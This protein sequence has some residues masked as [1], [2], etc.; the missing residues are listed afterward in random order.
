MHAYRGEFPI[1]F[2][3]IGF[4]TVVEGQRFLELFDLGDAD[5]VVDVACGT[6]GP[7]LWVAQQTGAFVVGI[8]PSP[9]GLVA[10]RQRALDVGLD[11]RSRFEVGTFEHTN[12]PD[13]SAEVVMSIEALQY[14]P[15]KRAAIAEFLRA[16]RP[17]GRLGFICFEVDPTKVEGVPVL[18][19]DPIPDYMPLLKE[20]GFHVE[21]YEETPDWTERVYGAFGAIVDA[22][23]VLTVEMGD[24]AAAGALA[25]AMLTVQLRPYPRRVLVVARK[26][27]L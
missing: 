24:Q 3:H 27:G 17:G 8:D 23:D 19:V 4:L 15:D 11:N 7:A 14:A 18:G 9:T 21:A 1:E 20:V 26:P 16:L 5:V 10:A 13:G 25:E 6:G 2:A 22:A 12:E